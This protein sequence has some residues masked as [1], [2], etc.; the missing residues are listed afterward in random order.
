MNRC[1]TCDLDTVQFIDAVTDTGI[2]S[3]VDASIDSVFL[4][5]L[6]SIVV[7]V[8]INGILKFKPG[9]ATYSALL[10]LLTISTEP[11]GVMYHDDQ[12]MMNENRAVKPP[13]M[14]S[15]KGFLM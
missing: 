3:E 5:V 2:C 10:N 14:I 11:S 12:M 1:R 9:S 15:N 4:I 7:V 6:T 8:S 13:S